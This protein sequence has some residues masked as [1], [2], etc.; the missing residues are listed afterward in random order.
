VTQ[1]GRVPT[2]AE[3]QG[4]FSNAYALINTTILSQQG[5]AAALAAPRT[6]GLYYQSPLNANGFPSGTRYS[7]SNQYVPVPNNNLSTQLAQNPL[8]KYLLAAFPTPSNPGPYFGFYRTDGL[9]LN[10]G[11]NVY[12]LRG[13]S[14]VDNRYAFR[15][16]HNL[17]DRD[18]LFVRFT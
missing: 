7:N 17:S 1:Q 18:R 15:I 10:N 11:N 13:V 2:P 9:W 16:D 6:G 3:L 5:A 8:A 12:Y 14:N 4:D